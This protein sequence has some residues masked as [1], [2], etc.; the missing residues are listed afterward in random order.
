MMTLFDETRIGSLTLKNRIFR[1]AT[2]EAMADENGT[3]TDRLIDV[4]RELSAGGVGLIFTSATLISPEATKLHA[5]MCISDQSDLLNFSSLADVIHANG[6]PVVMQLAFPGKN[7]EMWSP[8]IPSGDEIHLIAEEFGRS[9]ALAK[10]A[11]FDGVQIHAG[12]GFFLSQFL[13]QR[14]NTRSDEYGGP[15]ENRIRFILE[16]YDK[17]RAC[18]GEE[19]PLFIK[20]NCSDFEEDDGVN[21]ACQRACVE[22][23]RR[24]IQ[25]IEITGGTGIPPAEPYPYPESVFRDYAADIAKNVHAPIILVCMNRSTSVMTD[26]LNSTNIRYFSLSRPFLRQPDLVQIWKTNPETR[27][28]CTSCDLCRNPEGNVCPFR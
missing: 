3:P 15:V 16:I 6:C 1:S 12:H 28:E 24:G 7:G 13:N 20:I 19:F 22:L 25:G 27:S 18:T 23:D 9:A 17:I 8:E 5:M 2:W 4:Y 11:G 26:I 21:Q 14:K 10:R